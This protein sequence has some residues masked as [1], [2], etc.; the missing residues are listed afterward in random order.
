MSPT[1]PRPPQRGQS[2]RLTPDEWSRVSD[3]CTEF[4]KFPAKTAMSRKGEP[5]TES[6][7]LLDGI[8]GRHVP[9][10]HRDL[11]EMVAIEVP[12][13]FVDLHSFPTGALDHDV[14]AI[15]A[16]EVAVYPHAALGRLMREH[17]DTALS[18]WALTMLDGAIHR[19]WSFRIGAL[20]AMGRV[21]NF[22]CEMEL[23]LRMAGL[24]DDGR[25][26]LPLTQADVGEACG[27]SAVHVNRVIRDLR[28]AGYCTFREGRVEIRDM[29][30]L[31]EVGNFEPSFLL[32][33]QSFA[34]AI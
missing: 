1:N 6:L 28:A 13:D 32:G 2:L 15:T 34:R 20:R 26:D 31:R 4:R 22:L 18:L 24:G 19:Y 17:P 9:G 5:L 23:R 33:H 12:G 10:P 25:F 11:R 8:V 29:D 3:C 30:R 27:M 14:T 16:V 21:A 7:L